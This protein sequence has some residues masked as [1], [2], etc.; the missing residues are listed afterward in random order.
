[1]SE[2]CDAVHTA[3][4]RGARTTDE[5]IGECSRAGLSYRPETVALFLRLSH[6][7]IER[8]G[9]WRS[10]A[11][12]KVDRILAGLQKAFATGQTYIPMH[13]LSRYFDDGEP[14]TADD[15]VAACAQTG[16]YRAKG[17]LILRV[18]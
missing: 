2:L 18:Q 16:A 1:M 3:I 13:R 9:A 15:I 8:D 11:R 4:S 14:I 17:K 7:T 5:I 12:S 10:S 6:A